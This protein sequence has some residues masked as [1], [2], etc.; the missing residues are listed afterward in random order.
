MAKLYNV[1]SSPHARSPLTT[2]KV[3]RDVII[4]L[5]PTTAIGIYTHGMGAVMVI[6]A[7]IISAVLTEFIFDKITHKANTITDLSAVVTGLLLAL[8]MPE[9]VSIVLPILGGV[10]AILVVKCLFGG[11]GKNFMNPALAARC[12][13]LISFSGAMTNY[14]IDAVSAATPLADLAAGLQVNIGAIM[15]G[16]S[17]GCIGSSAIGLIIGGLFLW[18]VGGITWEIPVAAIASFT[19]FIAIFGGQGLNPWFL[20]THVCS[21][22]ILMGAIFMATDPVTSPVTSKGQLLFGVFVGVLGGFFR[23]KGTAA[24]SISYAIIISNLFVPLINANIVPVPH[25]HKAPKEKGGFKIPAAAATLCAITLIA[26]LAL[27]GVFSMTEDTIEA[28]ELAKAAESYAEVVPGAESF[29]VDEAMTAAIEELNGEVYGSDFGKAYINN[30]IAGLDASGNVVGYVIS[31]T[32]GDGFDGNITLSVGISTDG[33]V[34]GIAF[35]ELNETAGMGMR[36]DEED[37]KSQFAG[38]NV[39]RFTLNKAGGSTADDEIDSISGASISSGA[40][41]NAVNAALDFF[42]NNAN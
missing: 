3:M 20:L 33:T 31:A 37:F 28:Q 21:G 41:V 39:S 16:T 18:T 25:G 23:I 17:N 38:V 36:C 40:V 14:Q 5:L 7:C 15:L 6:A 42:A 34:N 11:L 4:A 30:A 32:S 19:A 8:C 35:T 27:S 1:S 22:G 2:S 10:F 9:G 24:D 29:E 13:L 12:F 26:G